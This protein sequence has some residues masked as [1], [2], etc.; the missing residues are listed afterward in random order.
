MEYSY[1]LWIDNPTTTGHLLKLNKR[2]NLTNKHYNFD[3]AA[4]IIYTVNP[5]KEKGQRIEIKSMAD[6]AAFDIN[7]TYKVAINS[8]RSNGGGGHLEIGLGIPHDKI[9]ERMI[10]TNTRDLR[11]IIMEDLLK[12]KKIN[13]KPLNNW[14]FVPQEQL[15]TYIETDKKLLI[16]HITDT[17]INKI[18]EFFKLQL[19]KGIIKNVNSKAISVMC[20]SIRFQ[21][22]ILW[23]IY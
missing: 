23:H 6:G 18:E 1:D 14:K 15:S 13:I 22:T 21:S 20:F 17:I 12:M 8:Y 2:N 16:S 4:G 3:S 10:Q 5:F 19:E 11:G 7:K 9:A